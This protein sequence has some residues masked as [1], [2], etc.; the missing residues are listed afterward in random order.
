[1]VFNST[2]NNIQLY[3]GGSRSTRRK[4]STCRKLLTNFITLCCIEYTLPWKFFPYIKNGQVQ[5]L[6]L[7][8]A[9]KCWGQAFINTFQNDWLINNCLTS[10]E[11]YFSYIQDDALFSILQI[12][13]KDDFLYPCRHAYM[14]PLCNLSKICT[15]IKCLRVKGKL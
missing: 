15:I 4:L 12:K 14:L 13:K 5:N 3:R 11:V 1:M 8:Y 2:F 9:S 6:N 10:S 7:F